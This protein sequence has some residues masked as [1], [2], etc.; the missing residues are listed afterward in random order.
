MIDSKIDQSYMTKDGF[1][2]GDAEEL[3]ELKP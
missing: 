3:A 2:I 1:F